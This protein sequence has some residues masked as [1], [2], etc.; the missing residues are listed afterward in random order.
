MNDKRKRPLEGKVYDAVIRV[1]RR[2]G[3]GEDGEAW[4]PDRQR[5]SILG[6]AEMDGFSIR[7]WIDEADSVSGGSVDREGLGMALDAA[8]AGETDGV[9]VAKVDRFARTIVGG[10]TAIAKLE[11]AASNLISAKEGMIVGDEKATATDKLV[12]HF[13]LMLA[14]WQRDTLTEE[15]EG[16]RAA[17][18]VAGIHPRAA[19]GY[20]RGPGRRLVP[21]PDEAPHVLRMFELRAAGKSYPHIAEALNADGI[22]PR[23]RIRRD[24]KDH[25]KIGRRMTAQ[26]WGAPRVRE[27]IQARVYMG[28]AHSGPFVNDNAHEAI[29]PASL[30]NAA[31]GLR[32]SVGRADTKSYM[33]AGLV[34]CEGCGFSMGGATQV[35]KGRTYRQ[36]KCRRLLPDGSRCPAPGNANA[37]DLDAL[38]EARFAETYFDVKVEPME[39]DDLTHAI[40]AE[41]FARSE[42]RDYLT[43]DRYMSL[44]TVDPGMYDEGLRSRERRLAECRDA[45]TSARNAVLRVNHPTDLRSKWDKMSDDDKR[46]YLA[47]AFDAIGILRAPRSV[48][49]IDRATFYGRDEAPARLQTGFRNRVRAL[50]GARAA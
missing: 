46:G 20:M 35:I 26:A 6:R 9:A 5:E 18:I 32:K 21:Q 31:N 44:R 24:G 43:N 30:W 50:R 37:D 16:I 7:R 13:Y 14:Q 34:R 29:V 25:D 3:R 8:L 36:Y 4:S 49:T 39:S 15:W 23:T 28:V 1:S 33:L 12:R 40:E 41:D 42:L 2:N 48:P 19:Y 47:D 38:A 22:T 27:I 17:S 45:V 10:L 11:D